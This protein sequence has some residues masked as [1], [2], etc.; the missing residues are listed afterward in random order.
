MFKGNKCNKEEEILSAVKYL[1][2]LRQNIICRRP[3]LLF[4]VAEDIHVYEGYWR[5]E[6]VLSEADKIMKKGS[7]PGETLSIFIPWTIL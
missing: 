3:L 7:W 5:V 2:T 4:I 1:K 6:V